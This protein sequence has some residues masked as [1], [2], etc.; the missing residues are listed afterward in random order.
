MNVT[1]Q[2]MIAL[3]KSAVLQEPQPLPEG[4]EIGEAMDL[5]RIH[6]IAALVYDG[7]ELC[8]LSR[9]DPAM[10]KLFRAY[11]SSLLVNE[12][13]E[14]EIGR[15]FRA[16]EE[17]GIDYMPLKGCNMK[18]LYPKPEMRIMGDADVL[19]RLDQYGRIVPVMESLGFEQKYESDHE[20]VWRSPALELELH[21]HLIPSYNRDLY[22]YFGDGWQM[23]IAG[24]GSRWDM[25]PEDTFVFLFTHFAKHYRDGGIGCRHVL[26]LWVYLRANPQLDM[27]R[28]LAVLEELNLGQ[29]YGHISRMLAVWFD[30]AQPD[31]RT[32]FITEFIFASGSWGNMEQR[33][34]TESVR[35]M[36]RTGQGT[37]GKLRY[38]W[39]TAFPSLGALQKKYT[40]LKKA[41]WLLPGVWLV[42]L[43]YKPI[44]ERSSLERHKR[45]VEAMTQENLDTHR[46][47]LK[48]VGLDHRRDP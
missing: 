27:D 45:V 37:G 44:F 16:F 38:L 47:M 36:Q 11:C 39:H 17:N 32:E 15:I 18:A 22:A 2:G 46:Q 35:S 8:G 1:Q 6:H 31:E 40:V 10:A 28:V 42:R 5:I 25:T 34:V 20:L 21:K 13:Q 7:A 26:D 3:M 41:P 4:F 43:V 19:I 48:F 14:R 33:V 29:F 24:G 30:G 23:A 9:Q 12:G